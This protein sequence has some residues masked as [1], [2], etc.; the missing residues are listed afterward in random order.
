M[1]PPPVVI[2]AGGASRR[3]GGG[4]KGLR[5][6]AGRPLLT[7]VIDRMMPQCEALA[8]NTN[9]AA[10]DYAVFDLPVLPDVRPGRPGPLAGL[11]TAMDWAGRDG[12]M[13]VVTVPGDT[14]F[15]PGDL[16]PQFLLAAEDAPGLPVLATSGGRL[17]PVAGLWPLALR[18]ALDR[19]LAGGARRMMAFAETAGAV[20][21]DFPVTGIDPFFNVNTPDDLQQAE[22]A[23]S[24]G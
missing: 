23:L 8:L 1:T 14:P 21:V 6:L 2:L 4:D 10:A 16:V 22:A 19:A 15:L 20:T 3:M 17:H 5:L 24:T 18:D 11:L 7:H 9:G 12:A 13:Q